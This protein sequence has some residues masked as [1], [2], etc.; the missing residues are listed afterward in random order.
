MIKGNNM[1]YKILNTDNIKEYISSI[2]DIKNYFENDD[3]EV[4]EIGDGN[5]NYVFIIKSKSDKN[6]ALILKQAVPYLRC[7]G[8]DFSLKRERMTYEI[9]A[10]KEFSQNTTEHIP[11]IYY[12]SEEMSSVFMQYLDSHIIMRSGLISQIKYPK[13][14]E[15]I[16]DYLAQNLFKTSSLYLDSVSKR[17]FVDKFNTNSELCAISEDFLFTFA[18][19]EHPTNADFATG[20]PL[21]EKLIKNQTFK[22][23]SLNLKYRFMTKNDAL[24]HGDLHTGSIMVNEDETYVIDPEFS[25]VGPFGFD[26][27]ALIGNLIMSFVSHKALGNDEYASWVLNTIDE[28]LE[29]FEAKFL[30]LWDEQ[31]S[32]ALITEGYIDPNYLKS[33]KQSFMKDIFRDTAGFAGIKMT[34]RMFGAAGVADIRDI[35]D[36]DIKEKAMELCLNISTRLVTFHK[37]LDDKNVLLDIIKNEID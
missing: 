29:K 14:S 30:K 23:Q 28:V 13:F 16:S 32:S 26:I 15:H 4:E 10:L 18:F 12:T 9:R 31:K 11:K 21:F 3:L 24:L 22:E 17:E 8:E 34:R 35:E 25:F 6:K 27:G 20:H 5:I 33:F 36:K 7:L 1:E 2:E 19:M 37:V